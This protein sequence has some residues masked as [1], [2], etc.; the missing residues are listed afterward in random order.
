MENL[1]CHEYAA[2]VKT[3]KKML[4]KSTS[5]NEKF[6]MEALVGENIPVVTEEMG[7]TI[8][9]NKFYWTFSKISDYQD[10]DGSINMIV[11]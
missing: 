10:Y 9:T 7:L 4:S 1:A 11:F 5:A 8:Q 6:W 3:K 2:R